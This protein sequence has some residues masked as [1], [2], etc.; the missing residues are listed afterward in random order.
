MLSSEGYSNGMDTITVM[1]IATFII[2]SIGATSMQM[3]AASDQAVVK[4]HSNTQW[5]GSILDSSFDS[6]TR[7]GHGD[8]NIPIVCTSYGIYSLA[9][10]KQ[11]AT[12]SL[13]VSVTQDNETLDT[14][15]T[16][17]AYGVVTLSGNCK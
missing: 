2:T 16:N 7:D 3:V 4:I 10:Q 14:T 13:M 12:G 9:I 6:A 17:A 11:T 15:F 1:L 8:A 5:S